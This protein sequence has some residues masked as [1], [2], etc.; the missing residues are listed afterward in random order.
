MKFCWCRHTS[1]SVLLAVF[2]ILTVTTTTTRAQEVDTSAGTAALRDDAIHNKNTQEEDKRLWG[3]HPPN[4][5]HLP[6][7]QQTQEDANS[8]SNH[9]SDDSITANVDAPTIPF[10]AKTT[11]TST[12]S[13]QQTPPEANSDSNHSA[14][15]ISANSNV[16]TNAPTIPF[17]AKTSSTSTSSQQQ[18]QQQQELP[19]PQQYTPPQGF[20]LT[21]RVYTDPIDKLAHFDSDISIRLPY[22]ECGG[23]GSTTVPINLLHATIRHLLAGSKPNLYASQGPHPQLVVCLTTLDIVL[24]SGETQTFQPGHV[25]LL[26]NVVRGGHK[27]VG[28]GNRDDMTVLILTLPQQYHAVGKEQTCLANTIRKS[29]LRD[30]CPPEN[31]QDSSSTSTPGSIINA[32]QQPQ[33][34]RKL[35]LGFLGVA[36]TG[37]AG[38]FLGKVAPLWL[39]VVFGGGCFVT[40]GTYAFVKAGDYA[41]EELQLWQERRQLQLVEETRQRSSSETSNGQHGQ[42]VVPPPLQE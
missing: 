35:V 8:N 4:D 9:S 12:S 28:H 26:E 41:L 14:D 18:Q 38:D 31:N 13:Q 1:S 5:A 15:N 27:L 16:N 19:L 21:A 11:S 7:Q 17:V 34:F 33:I 39:A 29:T 10:V 42:H 3:S 40:G 6:Q 2:L 23:A 20:P 36:I 32:L 24:N 37:V 22:W 30:P 25:I